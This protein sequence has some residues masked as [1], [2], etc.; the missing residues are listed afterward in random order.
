M[1]PNARRY[2]GTRMR[3][4]P[5]Q[6]HVT[7]SQVPVAL[8]SLKRV[9]NSIKITLATFL[10]GA[11]LCLWSKI[12]QGFRMTW[13]DQRARC[14]FPIG[15]ICI[16][17]LTGTCL[18]QSPSV[19][20]RAPGP[21][22]QARNIGDEKGNV[23]NSRLGSLAAE[24]VF[25][26]PA[27]PPETPEQQAPT[28]PR[29]SYQNGLLTVEST[30]S[31]LAD[32]LNGI[33]S[34]AGIQF[35]GIQG[36]SEKVAAKLGPAPAN[37]VLTNLLRGSRFDYI[38]I[39]H[40]DNPALVERVI[41][42]PSSNPGAAGVVAGQPATPGRPGAVQPGGNDEEESLGEE[43]VNE[44]APSAPVRQPG[45][46]SPQFG[47]AAPNAGQNT[48]QKTPQ[49]LLE[50]LKQLQQQQQQQNQQNPNQFNRISAPIKPQN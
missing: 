2:S 39:G 9:A 16:V 22:A 48:G 35:E 18:A 34:R 24:P 38:I 25:G 33:R 43:A 41:L 10:S 4:A 5:G 45:L 11:V 12:L 40:P 1:V 28:A 26:P 14:A 20:G 44:E 47:Q 17:I 37:E 21:T 3:Q 36:A 46:P 19:S 32:I 50:E 29:I 7:R 49:Q 8:D 15:G 31:R 30:N 6:M 13:F 27:P 42:S 23:P